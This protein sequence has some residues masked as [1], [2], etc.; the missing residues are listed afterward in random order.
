[1]I[2]ISVNKQ[3]ALS[4]HPQNTLPFYLKKTPDGYEWVR[5]PSEAL[6][7]ASQEEAEKYLS[8]E[9]ITG[10]GPLSVDKP[11]VVEI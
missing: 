7:F 5:H 8:D 10:G 6:Q 4:N 1:M 2:C 11:R 9:K 3:G